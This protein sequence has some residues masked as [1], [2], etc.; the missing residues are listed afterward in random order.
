MSLSQQRIMKVSVIAII[1]F[2]SVNGLYISKSTVFSEKSVK[3]ITF[4]F[5]GQG[6]MELNVS[7]LSPAPDRLSTISVAICKTKTAKEYLETYDD[8]TLCRALKEHCEYVSP[9]EFYMTINVTEHSQ[10][11]I[12]FLFC[13][14]PNYIKMNYKAHLI[15]KKDIELSSEDFYRPVIVLIQLLFIISN[16]IALIVNSILHRKSFSRIQL[17]IFIIFFFYLCSSLINSGFWIT[18]Y[19][20]YEKDITQTISHFFTVLVD[21]TTMAVLMLIGKGYKLI[22][23]KVHFYEMKLLI[24]GFVIFCICGILECFWVKWFVLGN[25]MVILGLFLPVAVFNV[26]TSNRIINSHIL[27]AISVEYINAFKLKKLMLKFNLGVIFFYIIV[28]TVNFILTHFIPNE[29]ILITDAVE[30]FLRLVLMLLLS[31]L[32]K[33]RDYVFKPLEIDKKSYL[34][35]INMSLN[36]VLTARKLLKEFSYIT[37]PSPALSSLTLVGTFSSPINLSSFPQQ[38]YLKYCTWKSIV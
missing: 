31:I 35:R 17:F 9:F 19:N 7:S 32:L 30:C 22:Y 12:F 36:T 1:L 25:L 27:I 16:V 37:K 24:L 38:I 11:D 23:L 14:I 3:I 33:T 6:R 8:D 34:N 20:G 18:Y 4:G 2:A 26:S 13:D 21:A 5:D 28:Y 29:Y 15:N 10:Y